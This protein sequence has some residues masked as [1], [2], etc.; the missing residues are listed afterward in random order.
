MMETA[1]IFRAYG[2]I[3]RDQHPL[4]LQKRKA[5]N[6]I[7]QCRTASLGGRLDKCD[8]CG[9]ERPFYNSCRNR[10]CPKCGALARERWIE[11]RK[12]QVL[13]VPYFHSVFTVPDS[14]NPLMLTNQKVLYGI[15]FRAGTET[16]LELGRDPKHL[17]AEIGIIATLHTWGRNLLDHPHLH[18]IVTGGGLSEDGKKW[19][20]PRRTTK[21]NDF[22]VH[23]DVLSDLF[24]KKFL[25]YLKEAF[26][27]GNLSFFG[28]T[29]YLCSKTAFCRFKNELYDRKWIT[30]CKPPFSGINNVLE[31]LGRYIHRVAISNRRIVK[32]EDEKVTFRWRDHRDDCEKLM[33]VDVLEFIRR[34]LL[35]VLPD[36]FFK[37]R[38]YGILSSRNRKTKLDLCMRILGTRPVE[39]K[40]EHD[41][42]TF[43]FEMT[44]ID[45]RGCPK[46][47]TG[48][49]NT[50][51]IVCFAGHSPP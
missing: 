48:R 15:L 21:G 37:V 46:C 50:S 35:H 43:F 51:P 47:G 12:K 38:Y 17:G 14:L 5:M 10:H 11:A 16:L 18:C 40:T 20:R 28:K 27:S 41:W 44:G 3:Y 36:G 25:A 30:Y 9:H 2:N 33:T 7:V 49:M 26:D 29:G 6:A 32:L 1:D 8:R 23:V 24:K 19:V 13:P 45:L 39:R 31:Y 4:P 22:F 42:R 34:F